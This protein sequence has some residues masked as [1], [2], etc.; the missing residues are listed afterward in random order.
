MSESESAPDRTERVG[1]WALLTAVITRLI[2]SADRRS[3]S[4]GQESFRSVESRLGRARLSLL[5]RVQH[6][7][8][9]RVV[10]KRTW[11]LFWINLGCLG[12]NVAL[13]FVLI[14]RMGVVG[15]AL[16]TLGTFAVLAFLGTRASRAL[17]QRSFQRGRALAVFAVASGSALASYGIDAWRDPLGSGGSLLVVLLLKLAACAA[18]LALLWFVVLDRDGREGLIRLGRDIGARAR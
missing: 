17:G 12:G 15:A 3:I 11:P 4:A 1:T 9:D 13:N 18:A 5:R 8:G 2:L 10:A 7:P 16:A 6:Q 14:P